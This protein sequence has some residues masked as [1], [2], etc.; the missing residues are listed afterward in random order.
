MKK[1]VYRIHSRRG[2][3]KNTD[4]YWLNQGWGWTYFSST[5]IKRL[6]EAT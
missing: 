2:F 3:R 5:T 4:H 6:P 1:R